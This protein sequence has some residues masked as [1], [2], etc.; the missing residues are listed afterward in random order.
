MSLEKA[1][2]FL[3]QKDPR[4]GE[5]I[6][7]TS[8]APHESSGDV[9]YDLLSCIVGQQ[10]HYR[11]MAPY[12]K[13]F[14]EYFQGSY[15]SP[16]KILNLA[17]DE[18]GMVKIARAKYQTVRQLSAYWLE[19]QLEN[20]HWTK[21]SEEEFRKTFAEIPGIG[22]WSLDMLLLYTLEKPNIFPADDYHVKIIMES[23]YGL[24]G[25]GKLKSRM[26]EIAQAW[27]PHCSLAV[28]YLLAY[29]D[30]MKKK[31]KAI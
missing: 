20:T 17:P 30:L 21:L 11:R 10:I 25:Q 9:F 4:L 13:K 14:L 3:A 16:E 19:Q 31:K 7:Q 23:T 12:F 29:K 1:S 5:I 6:K 15:P 22:P 8:L 28:R 27:E 24:T 26:Q 18:P 2:E